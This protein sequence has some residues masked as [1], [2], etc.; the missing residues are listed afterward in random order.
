[1]PDHL[2]IEQQYARKHFWCTG[3]QHKR[4]F[5]VQKKKKKP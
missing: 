1:M 3:K 4:E 2:N 5:H